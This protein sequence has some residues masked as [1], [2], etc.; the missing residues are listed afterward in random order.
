MKTVLLIASYF[1]LLQ[2]A[3]SQEK[4]LARELGYTDQVKQV[5]EVEYRYKDALNKYEV[6]KERTLSFSKGKLIAETSKSN[7][8]MYTETTKTYSYN[9]KGQLVSV[10][11]KTGS[12]TPVVYR[13]S[14]QNGK[15][16]NKKNN[17]TKH[18]QE[19]LYEY[20]SKGQLAKITTRKKGVVTDIDE[21]SDYK[22][23][24]TYTLTE[25]SY[26]DGKLSYTETSTYVNDVKQKMRFLMQST[27]KTTEHTYQYDQRGKLV[28][29][30]IDNTVVKNEYK[31]DDRGNAFQVKMGGSPNIF[32]FCK[33]QYNDG[34]ALG[35]TELSAY[36]VQQY[37]KNSKSYA[38]NKLDAT[39]LTD[40]SSLL[41]MLD[42]EETYE[43]LKLADNSFRVRTSDGE[44]LT[45]AVSAAKSPNGTDLVIYE[46]LMDQT[47]IYKGFY[48]ASTATDKW[49][50]MTLLP[51]SEDGCYWFLNSATKGYTIIKEGRYVN[52][53]LEK[54]KLVAQ[55]G[56]TGN[57]LLQQNGVDKFLMKGVA[58]KK[59]DEFHPL[60]QIKAK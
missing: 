9:D 25:Y 5:E 39:K 8:I 28:E 47:L 59:M 52:L 43:V 38:Y 45:K 41:S 60:E 12:D 49:M 31:Y 16:V 32:R 20:N 10:T 6:V 7:I 54:Y 21:Y 4:T 29:E 51:Y 48:L 11:E 22:N 37:D 17:D 23:A 24:G 15:L 33:I 53:S 18:P 26:W 36:F 1:L 27:G 46:A 3:V 30:T 35:T 44:E 55:P 57:Y 56:N 14:Y 50:E 40:V 58:G 19:V 42:E 34:L 2:T 13:Y